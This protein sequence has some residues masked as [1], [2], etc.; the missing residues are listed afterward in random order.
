MESREQ[1]LTHTRELWRDLPEIDDAIAWLEP[2]VAVEPECAP[3]LIHVALR[4]L[5]DLRDELFEDAVRVPLD[6]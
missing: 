1:R 6:G 5:K 3:P 4:A 2:L